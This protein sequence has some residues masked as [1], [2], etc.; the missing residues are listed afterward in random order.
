MVTSQKMKNPVDGTD[1]VKV[2]KSKLSM[3]KRSSNKSKSRLIKLK[4]I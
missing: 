2:G 4:N 3:L 1:G